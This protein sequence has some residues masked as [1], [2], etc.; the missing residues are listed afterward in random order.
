MAT[1]TITTTGHLA[2]TVEIAGHTIRQPE[3][4]TLAHDLVSLDL[5]GAEVSARL[6]GRPDTLAQL[7][8]EALDELDPLL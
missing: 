6:I 1:L 8:R 2:A 4:I 5:G 7:L 3:V